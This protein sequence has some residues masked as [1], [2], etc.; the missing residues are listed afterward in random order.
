VSSQSLLQSILKGK[1]NPKED[2]MKDDIR[3]FMHECFLRKTLSDIGSVL[4]RDFV[5]KREAEDNEK[6]FTDP[7]PQMISLATREIVTG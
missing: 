5:A 2:I 1:Y 7:N 6:S 4:I 3:A